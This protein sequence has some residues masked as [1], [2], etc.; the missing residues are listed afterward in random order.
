MFTGFT[1]CVTGLML[2]FENDMDTYGLSDKNVD[3]FSSCSLWEAIV[4]IDD[5]VNIAFQ[6]MFSTVYWNSPAFE[7]IVR[8]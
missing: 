1:L 6:S 8:Y 3:T 2:S 7:Q 4:S 5:I